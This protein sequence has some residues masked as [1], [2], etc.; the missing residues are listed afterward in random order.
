MLSPPTT[1]SAALA[2][3]IQRRFP[4]A[5]DPWTVLANET[6]LD[7]DAVLEQ[8]ARWLQGG[9]LREISAVFEGETLGYESALVA[10][11][12]PVDDLERVAR[13]IGQHPTVTH[14]YERDHHMNLWF[15]LAVPPTMGIAGTLALLARET[16]VAESGFHPLR[17]GQT[18]K[19]GVSFDLESRRNDT[20]VALG[21]V[22]ARFDPE[23]VEV[24]MIRALQTPL[25]PRE[26]P[27]DA[28][29][30]QAGVS[31][32]Q[33]LCFARGNMGRAL[34]RY[35]ATFRHR[36]LGVRGNGMAVWN[37]AGDEVARASASCWRT[38]LR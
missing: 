33:L 25:A 16:E 11:S 23:P 20:K 36:R 19:I 32:E 10:V 29:A 24:A 3:A 4:L 6:G 18:F 38:P 9:E 17:R 2:K 8:V 5:S 22:S 15:T 27:F 21:D 1:E 37:V 31:A 14:C 7:R 12:V 26:R 13:V 35:V 28:L 30:D 34:R